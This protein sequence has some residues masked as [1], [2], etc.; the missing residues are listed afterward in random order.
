MLIDL[1]KHSIISAVNPQAINQFYLW[2]SHVLIATQMPQC[3]HSFCGFTSN[4]V[5]VKVHIKTA[6][7]IMILI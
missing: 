1:L 4:L 3:F 2:L 5:F 7:G 6:F